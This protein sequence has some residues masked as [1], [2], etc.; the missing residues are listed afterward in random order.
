MLDGKCVDGENSDYI[1]RGGLE[2]RSHYTGEFTHNQL[3]YHSD[4]ATSFESRNPERMVLWSPFC[5]VIFLCLPFETP[6]R[7]KFA[8]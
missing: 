7:F 5:P 8:N 2:N 6:L 4:T 1:F 3:R